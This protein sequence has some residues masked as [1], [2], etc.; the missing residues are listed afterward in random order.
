MYSVLYVYECDDTQCI[1][2]VYS[3]DSVYSVY[4]A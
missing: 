3:V 4:R 2:S 1:V